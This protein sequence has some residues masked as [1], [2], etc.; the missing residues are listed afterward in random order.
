MG[1]FIREHASF[2]D[3][4]LETGHVTASAWVMDHSRRY[5]LLTHHAKLDRWLQL[6]GHIE[7]DP[8]VLRAAA[9][10]AQE[11]S[12][13]ESLEP[14]SGEIFDVDIHVIPAS[15]RERKHLHY[16]IRYLFGADRHEALRVS[17]ESKQLAW[18]GVDALQSFTRDASVLRMLK[19]AL[20]RGP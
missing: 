15:A 3:R 7:R 1:E 18:V 4:V 16:D 10:E 12:G 6:G 19:K 13:L 8:S 5:V 2:W 14:V 11:E 9:R 20:L 17:Q